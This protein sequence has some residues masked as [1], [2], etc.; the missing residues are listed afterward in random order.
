M[1]SYPPIPIP[2]RQRWKNFRTR[3]LPVMVFS[4]AVLATMLLWERK[5]AAPMMVGEV[6]AP[7]GP[8]LA[9]ASGVVEDFS[10]Q[11]YQDVRAGD[12]IGRIRVVPE[13]QAAAALEALRAEIEMIRMGA[14]DPVLDQRRN[15]LSWQGLRRDWM[16]ARSELASLRV[17]V[18]QAE[19]DYKRYEK[20]VGRG[21]E[22][23]AIFEQGRALYDSLFA[24][25]TEIRQLVDVLGKAVE[26]SQLPNEEGG[27]LLAEGLK[28]SLEWKEAELKSLEATMEPILLVAPYDG[29]IT[30]IYRRQGDFVAGGEPVVDIRASRADFIVGYAKQPFS[31]PLEIGMKIEVVQRAGSSASGM[32]RLVSI[33]PQYEAMPVGLTRPFQALAAERALPML[34]SLP[35]GLNLRPGEIVDLRLGQPGG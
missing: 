8:I 25:E 6:Y 34:I 2:L 15:V 28:S 12:V 1:S 30:L 13:L 29:R 31:Q 27:S 14:G 7:Q 10:V 24:E 17:R 4:M 22:A 26:D 19:A 20:L 23:Q 3:F 21:A 18:K 35:E 33:G 16:L 32:A 9:A 5:S 11:P